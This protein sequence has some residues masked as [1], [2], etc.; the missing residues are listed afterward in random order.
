[1]NSKKKLHLAQQ[2][3][4]YGQLM[5]PQSPIYNIG[6]Y[7]ILTGT[8]DTAL[9]KSIVASLSSVFDT[10]NFRY[11]F[12]GAEPLFY[13]SDCK[14]VY[15]NEIDFSNEQ[16]PER[17]A[18]EWMQVAI[19]T[20]F[21]LNQEKLYN[22]SLIKI[23]EDVHWWYCYNHHL[24]YDGYGFALIASYVIEEYDRRLHKFDKLVT[25][26]YPSY[27]NIIQKNNDYLKSKQYTKDA[28]YW[29]EKFTSIPDS[30]I[31]RNRKVSNIGGHRFSIH[32]SKSDKT[33][34]SRLT[35]ETKANLSQFTIAALLLYFGKTTGKKVFSFGVPIH[36]RISREER[37]VLGMF[38]SVLPFKGE[39]KPDDLLSDLIT[40]IKKVQ[41]NDYRHRQYPISHLNR[42]LKLLSKNR[43]QVFDIVVNYEPFPFPKSLSSG[44]HLAI[45]HLSTIVD[46]EDPLSFRWCDYGEDS[47]LILN[48]DFLQE[49]FEIEEIEILTERLL[50]ILRQ[51][52]GG[53][54][55]PVK[56]ISIMSEKEKYQLL[57]GF[58]SNILKLPQ[59]KT[60]LDLFENQV[61][62]YPNN[63]AIVYEDTSITYQDLHDRSNQLAH[64]I[65]RNYQIENNLIGICV[66]RNTD[67]I[68]S[69]LAVLKL[70]KA[71]V[72][73]DNN[74]PLDRITYI[75][76]DS[77][78]HLLITDNT[79]NELLV[80]NRNIQKIAL[81]R[82]IGEI[83]KEA[84]KKLSITIHP[85]DIAYVMYTSGTTG[86]PKG[87]VVK[88]ISVLNIA[89]SWEASFEV[90]SNTR[91]LQLAS[92]A[93][94]V[95]VG[96]F[97][98]SLLFGGQMVICPSHLRLDIVALYN[99]ITKHQITIFETTPSLGV[100][101]LDYIYE[102]GLDVSCL[103]Q[104]ILGSDIFHIHDYKRL[105]ERFGKSI[106]LI[107]SYGVT[108]ATIDSS[109]YEVEDVSLLSEV[110]TVPIGKPL[111]NTSFYV[112]DETQNLIPIGSIGELHIGGL[113]LAK[114]YLNMEALTQEKF[115]V[116]PFEKDTL[117]YRT[118][119]LARWLPCG[120]LDF[121][122]RGDSQVKIRG[123]R[124]EL[125][126]I[127]KV[128]FEI[129]S[130]E[131]C[132]VLAR[133]DIR[134][135]KEL[136]GYV[137]VEGVFD[138]EA[139]Q[140][141]LNK[142]LPEYM[143]PTLWV[144]LEEMPLT[145]N[146]KLDK[147]LLPEPDISSLST[148]AYVAPRNHVESTLA[149][150][151]Q[152][153][154]G[155]ERVGIHDNFFELGGHSLLIVQLISFLRK[156]DLH[157]AVKDI[158]L[159]P[160]IA[161]MVECLV[162]SSS[163]YQVPENGI[164]E[165]VTHISPAMV[166]LLDFNQED[167]DRVVAHI[168]GGVSNIQDI[169]P[170]SPLQEGMYFHY[171]M[172]NKN[173]GDPYVSQS[174]LSF[175]SKEKCTFFIEA[176]QFI[177]NRHDVLRTCFISEGLP[178]AVQVV[179]RE[180]KLSLEYLNIDTSKGILTELEL[181]K[182]TDNLWMDISKA[183][184]LQVKLAN[185]LKKGRYY[186]LLNQHHLVLD[187]IGM[188]KVISEIEQYLL[189]N[190]ANLP[191]PVLYRNFI[192][193]ILHQL[194]VNDSKSHFKKLLGTTDEPTYPFGLADVRDNISDIKELQMVLP[195]DLSNEIRKVCLELGISPAV[196][197]HAAYGIL[198]AK[199]S[200]IGSNYAIFGSLFSGRLQGASGA[201]DSLGLFINTLPFL[202]TL[203]GSVSEYIKK[204]DN[205][206]RE[207]LPYEH[208]PLSSIQN[209]SS[210][211]NDMPL[212]SALFNFRH[213]SVETEVE[214]KEE[215]IDLGVTVISD[216]ERTNYPFTMSVDDYGADFGLTTK[217]HHS[218]EPRR[219]IEYMII[220]L[221]TLL[222]NVATDKEVSI[223]SL[224]IIPERETTQLLTN[225][226]TTFQ[227]VPENK[228]LVELFSEQVQKNPLQTAL[229]Y[230]GESITYKEL[231]EKSNQLAHYL[232]VQG[233]VP[234]MLVGI[235]LERGFD[236]IVGI[237]GILK[238]GGA[239][240]PIDPTFPQ[241]RIDYILEDAGIHL[242]IST[243]VSSYAL[244]HVK[245]LSV[246]SLDS[247]WNTITDFFTGT[248]SQTV[249]PN[250][251]AYT[252]YTS[253]STGKPKGV[254][255]EHRNVVNLVTAQIKAFGI[256]KDDSVLQLANFVFDA[257][258][259]Q[260]FIT[261]SAGA[262]L[263]LLSRETIIDA[264]KVLELI[265]KERVTHLH[266][267]PSLL[268][269]LPTN[270]KL[271][272]LKRVVSGGEPC[273]EELML[274]WSKDCLF[275]NEYGPTEATVTATMK[276]FENSDTTQPM[277]IG[278]PIGNTQ[279]YITDASMNLVP[280]GIV[281]ELYIGGKG[282][283]RGYLNKEALTAEKF[284]VNPFKAN[285]IIYKTGDLARWLPDGTIE[286]I[287]RRDNQV[288][289]RGY[290][291]ELGE[292]ENVLSEVKGI[293]NSFVIAK[294]DI[295][296]NKRLVAYVVLEN[297]IDKEKI[298]EVLMEKLPDYMIPR[299]W[300]E[301]DKIPL[302]PNGKLDKKSLPDP[303]FSSI[304]NYVAPTTQLEKELCKVWERVL[305]LKKVGIK[306]DFFSIGGNS[307]LA[308]QVSSQM[309]KILGIKVQISDII[310]Y[311][312]IGVLAAIYSKLNAF[313]NHV[314]LVEPY[315]QAYNSNL[316]DMI[317]VH[318]ALGGTDA[319][320]CL[321]KLLKDKYNCIGIDNHNIYGEFRIN[322]LHQLA[323]F[324]LEEYIKKYPIEN[325]IILLGWSLGGAIA[326]EI[327]V[328]L[329]S[330]G[331]SDIQVILLDTYIPL[332]NQS[333]N[334]NDFDK[335]ATHNFISKMFAGEFSDYVEKLVGASEAEYMLAQTPISNRLFT[336]E[337][338]LFQALYTESDDNTDNMI[339]IENLGY[340]N[341]EHI[342]DINKITIIPLH[343][344]HRQILPFQ[345]QF[346]AENLSKLPEN[347]LSKVEVSNK[348]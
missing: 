337:I 269:I 25:K 183:P 261:L 125:G 38:S 184:L 222:E 236:M 110:S 334:I 78:L 274:R 219:I 217:V 235:C 130:I 19:D 187:N 250:H 348:A 90:D 301:L 275:Y 138:K 61:V 294:E 186:V 341:L 255:I 237:L 155:I 165:G 28:Y 150:I 210:V 122:G 344:Y 325:P 338:I 282:V 256:D 113:G 321:T 59:N 99:L 324:Y 3:V 307:I 306:D 129:E 89:L 336:T 214:G 281:G 121:I 318:S 16:Y 339:P 97:C 328:I 326:L 66:S 51:F 1:M 75:V 310:R 316:S 262:K 201:S 128:L 295:N 136:V 112:L 200:N 57:S 79:A 146:G 195:E 264:D 81:D 342:I 85:E 289:I 212:F 12:T 213:S 92:F 292:I 127:E 345:A 106:R 95:F 199:C 305:G 312:T 323:N 154:L 168:E 204:V 87:V 245:E 297:V 109:Y 288:K 171:L 158:F 278:T 24:I 277:T 247:D 216:Y 283:A 202:I 196:F 320:H 139:I 15:L 263:V 9:F 120:N 102:N 104:V 73:I 5:N 8:L 243:S 153:L 232:H 239:Y 311:K 174:L 346:I 179:L 50:F 142:S 93:F 180:A 220:T 17:R 218:I 96:D 152:N 30:V 208:T 296:R 206:L 29:Q 148:E 2:E 198:I 254:L 314:S 157:I 299:T 167:I 131:N 70:G 18:K 151:W 82:V 34:F 135:N 300:I 119:D 91:L 67:L 33:L 107:N 293:K 185:D 265:D 21:D 39:Y 45:K 333:P 193:H 315:E 231:D 190:S 32:I 319:Y 248:L 111:H 141:K 100:P 327:A 42:S 35:E 98:K 221:E 69:V 332:P 164:T 88:H 194:S 170:L 37:S 340:N 60:I 134:G 260:I 74:Y 228:T 233:V 205:T 280:E 86:K 114:E 279:I 63:I 268:S 308:I 27:F 72:P 160:T 252:I 6:G 83:E 276:A 309:S 123:Y 65:N 241:A 149:T 251:L 317:F 330:R 162:S 240:V 303:K 225:F 172:S 77:G 31:N 84:I 49:Y 286:F 215:S 169:Y 175:P 259:E 329:E 230:E 116:H 304:D 234:D 229:I 143:V 43:Q 145:A 4:Y 291:I 181:L 182:T 335:E 298:Q 178:H 14:E 71:Y 343:C 211:P 140:T 223:A 40:E 267:T 80:T 287:G 166:P 64:Y 23:A 163:I 7:A 238:S 47:S 11:D 41:R 26:R 52:D 270:E 246:V 302:T 159:N 177:V 203:E 118:G 13:I 147:K 226:N 137:V 76:E 188:K 273:S 124:I 322:D 103:K 173:E 272:S 115:I 266:A 62:Q 126:E 10:Y 257:S 224:N 53:L 285:D 271:P 197:F 313:Q 68:V 105:Y 284:V 46:L 54:T 20:V 290:R 156:N 44:L 117:L 227:E 56:D 94:D 55:K 192:G 207:L 258:V 189:G 249:T 347:Y 132:C 253:G 22:Y 242:V 58:N 36:N 144:E 161:G 331:Y 108:E 191:K 101:L 48:V 176:L 133:P 244:E 209:W